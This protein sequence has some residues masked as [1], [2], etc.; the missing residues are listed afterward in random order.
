[1]THIVR[2]TVI[3][4]ANAK[5]SSCLRMARATVPPRIWWTTS[6][7]ARNCATQIGYMCR[8]AVLPSSAISAPRNAKPNAFV[9][10]PRSKPMA[11]VWIKSNV[12]IHDIVCWSAV[13]VTETRHAPTVIAVRCASVHHITW[14][15]TGSAKRKFIVWTNK[16][17]F[18]A[19]V[20]EASM[21]ALGIAL[22]CA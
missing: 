13:S 12:P 5:Q 9:H 20:V 18:N 2:P 8:T 15:S 10:Q 16:S 11:Y 21:G 22:K 4:S 3:R 17:I 1:M 14:R 7:G 6:A 19:V